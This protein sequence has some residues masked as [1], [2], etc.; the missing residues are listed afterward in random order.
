MDKRSWFKASRLIASSVV[1]FFGLGGGESYAQSGSGWEFPTAANYAAS[2]SDSNKTLSSENAPGSFITVTLPCPGV[3]GA[4]WGMG[5]SEANG[6]GIVVNAPICGSSPAQTYILAGQKTFTSFSIPSN[7]NY[8]IFGLQSDG[9]NFRLLNAT[10]ATQ[11]FNG[12]VG[13]VGGK[14]WNYLFATGYSSTLTDNGTTLSSQFAG[15]AV[16]L[17]LPPTSL[18]PNGCLCNL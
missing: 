3:V 7:T 8:E 14:V 12:I 13:S 16:T 9:N 5:F 17:Y 4:G 15:G 6:K 18:L 11:R 1:P 10:D 2:S